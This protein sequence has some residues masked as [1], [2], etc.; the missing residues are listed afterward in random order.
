MHW[1]ENSKKRSNNMTK[2][3]IF[4]KMSIFLEFTKTYKNLYFGYNKKVKVYRD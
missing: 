3:S 2:W 4:I 1:P